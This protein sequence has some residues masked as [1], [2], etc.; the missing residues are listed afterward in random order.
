MYFHNIHQSKILFRLF[1]GIGVRDNQRK[2]D[3]WLYFEKE[4][5]SGCIA[6]W[7]IQIVS[8]NTT[9]R[10]PVNQSKH[11]LEQD[12]EQSVQFYLYLDF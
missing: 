5:C 6:F 11:K 7:Y 2:A 8:M 10:I 3:N 12:F 1:Y 4:N 9:S